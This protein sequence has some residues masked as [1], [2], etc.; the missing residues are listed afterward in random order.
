MSALTG[1][2]I[3]V[4]ATDGFEDAE[5]TSPVEALRAAGGEVIVLAP[6]TGSI[7]GKNG[8]EV[9]VDAT[10]SASEAK[11]FDGILL[12]GGTA[13]SD[14]IR[15]DEAAVSIVRKHV[16][17]G[18]PLGAICHAAWLLVEADVVRDRTVTS[19]PSLRTDLRNAGADWVDEECVCDQGLVTSRTPDDLPAFN[20]K[21]VEEIEEG[22]H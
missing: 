10:T 22:Q 1:K 18:M 6:E 20:A 19:Y 21:L 5:L 12:P 4:I 11:T 17:A 14:A 15:L 16:S 3:A 2:T 8:T 13:N 9:A 7:T